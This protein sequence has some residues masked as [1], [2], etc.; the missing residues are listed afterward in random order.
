M[1]DRYGPG[2]RSEPQNPHPGGA[3]RAIEPTEIYQPRTGA[4]YRRAYPAPESGY[5]VSGARVP[6][7]AP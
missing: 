1:A 4:A 7:P 6:H 3:T 5:P 2:E